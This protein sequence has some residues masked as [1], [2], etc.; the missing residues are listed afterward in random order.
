MPESRTA[1]VISAH[2]ADFVWRCG[3]AIAL[4]AQKG[5]EIT[6]VCL[7]FGERGESAKLWQQ[8]GMALE[9]VKTARRKEAERAAAAGVHIHASLYERAEAEDGLDGD[10]AAVARVGLD[11]DHA[12]GGLGLD[13][14]LNGHGDADL[15]VVEA[16]L[17]P[18]EN[19]AGLE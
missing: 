10:L 5:Y 9:K 15:E 2:A 3:G 7:S 17:R 11:G 4:H 19:S 14:A 18:V 8:E 16:L 12:A 6:V 1:L 13:H